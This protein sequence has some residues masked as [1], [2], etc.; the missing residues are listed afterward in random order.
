MP[1]KREEYLT[2]DESFM[3][4]ALAMA[5]R[6]KDPSTIV[7]ACIVKDNRILSTGYN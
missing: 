5:C 6:S 2:W 3:G 1:G 4:V 7:G